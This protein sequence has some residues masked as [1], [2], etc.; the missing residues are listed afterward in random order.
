[1]ASYGRDFAKNKSI[2]KNVQQG[3]KDDKK[4]Q[5]LEISIGQEK[6]IEKGQNEYRLIDLLEE[7]NEIEGIERIRLRFV[8]ANTYNR[9]VCGKII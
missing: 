6:K 2:D 3:V 5:E 8:R 7:I 9:R 4:I 1:M